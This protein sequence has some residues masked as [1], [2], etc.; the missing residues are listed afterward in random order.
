M[1]KLKT[2]EDLKLL[3]I[4]GR[5]LGRVLKML[6]AEAREGKL[7]SALDNLAYK[8][9]KAEGATPAFLNYKPEGSRIPYPASVC[10]SLN[11]EVVHGL[12][13]EL[14]LK[15]GDVLKIDL[16]VSYKGLITDAAATVVVGKASRKVMALLKATEEALYAAIAAVKAGGR[17]GDIG[18]A[19]E[20]RLKRGGFKIIEGLTGHG[21]GYNLHEDPTVWN[22]GKKGTGMELKEG[23]VL[24]I[25]PMASIGSRIALER[26]DGTFVTKDGSVAAHFEHTIFVT[27]SGC[28]I[29]TK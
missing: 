13:R 25:E 19:V 14:P 12:P 29:L 15:D 5:I 3:R 10:L 7:L 22:Y 16:G 8:Y 17:L 20:R 21:T 9:I 4:S 11:D 24:A 26:A 27:K 28:E 6:S 18:Y 1:V 23:L 2:Q